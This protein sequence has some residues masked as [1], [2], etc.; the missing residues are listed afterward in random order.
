MKFM[1]WATGASARARRNLPSASDLSG[2]ARKGMQMA[3]G[4]SAEARKGVATAATYSAE[5]RKGMAFLAAA[6]LA[7][8]LVAYMILSWRS[9]AAERLD[10]ASA[11]YELVTTRAA[12]AQKQGATRLTAADGV[13]P[14]FL[15]GMTPGVNAAKFQEL[16][17]QQATAAGL[18]V[19]RMQLVETGDDKA[20]TPYRI[21]L[22]IE[23]SLEQLLAFM[24]GIES[25]L[26]VM[27]VTGVEM[28]PAAAEG[29]G[30]GYPSEALLATLHIDAYGWRGAQ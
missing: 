13:A 8:L 14:M 17:G 23:G 25:S 7:V 5:A 6:G 16:A 11:E 3:A 24:T 2:H 15:E 28:Q 22:D 1:D 27:F 30:D 20:G 4:L 21:S 12:R 10:K 29:T 9:S 26:P 18:S 19:K